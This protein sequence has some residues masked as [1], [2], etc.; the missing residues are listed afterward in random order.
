MR[1]A[2]R[3]SD[4]ACSQRFENQ[5]ISRREDIVKHILQVPSAASL[6][7]IPGGHSTLRWISLPIIA[8][9]IGICLVS[10]EAAAAYY[11]R[12]GATGANNGT[13]WSNAY[14]ALPST[15]ERGAT[16]YVAAG[17]Y[18]SYSFNDSGTATITVKKATQSDHGTEVGWNSA[19]GTGQAFFGRIT[20]TQNYHVFDGNTTNGYGFAIQNSSGPDLMNLGDY[21]AGTNNN[22]VRSTSINC[23]GTANQR[24]IYAADSDSLIFENVEAWNCDN[25]LLGARNLSN[26]VIDGSH[27]HTRNNA[28]VGTH[29]DAIE[30]TSS[31]NV[32][33]RNTIFD[34]AGQILFFGGDTS[35]A[36]GRFD[37]YGNIFDGGSSSG[38]GICRNSD[39]TGGP[40][41]VYNNTFYGLDTENIEAGMNYGGIANNVFIAG[42]DK[43]VGATNGRAYNYYSTDYT[44]YSVDAQNQRGPNILRNPENVDYTLSNG[45]SSGTALSSFVPL[46][47]SL[48]NDRKGALRGA[49][50]IWDR[51]AFEFD[52]GASRPSA[53]S[54]LS[55]Q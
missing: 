20:F 45:T 50:G 44:D 30:I 48:R 17:S 41:Y 51:G 29:G 1:Q 47:G 39:G 28:G 12:A 34:W 31:S 25:D 3:S 2:R 8:L 13:D 5:V 32:T 46:Y 49:D 55:V 24:A 21:G 19:Y 43:T 22:T 23:N 53:P 36:N 38:Q 42:G 10:T 9:V 14:S 37:V 54:N 7:T 52:S 4:L 15:L 11:V 33:I 27:F 18:G 26:I 16:Y 40:V 6:T 35:G